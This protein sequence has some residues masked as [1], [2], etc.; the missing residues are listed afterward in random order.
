MRFNRFFY[1]ND[2]PDAAVSAADNPRLTLE[3]DGAN[4][5]IARVAQS[6]PGRFLLSEWGTELEKTAESLC[7]VGV[8]ESERGR[9]R[10]SCPVFLDA[11]Y[12]ALYALSA[13]VAERVAAVLEQ[14][15][16]EMTAIASKIDNGF[17]ASVNLYHL[18]CGGVF[19]GLYFDFLE[20]RRLVTTSKAHPSG[21]DYLVILYEDSARLNAWSRSLLCSYNRFGTEK[22]VFSSFGDSAGERRDFYR[23]AKRLESGR[24]GDSILRALPK[25]RFVEEFIALL[26]GG[27]VD[28]RALAAFEHFGY[29][30]AGRACV[31]VY[32]WR[33]DRAVLQEL[34]HL[35]IGATEDLVCAAMMRVRDAD[36]TANRHGVPAEDSANEIFHLIFG[37]VNEVLTRRGIAAAPKCRVGEG[38]YAKAFEVLETCVPREA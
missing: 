6:P 8:L 9:L 10:L 21:L 32:V 26:D 14:R 35:V 20:Q 15:G 23:T 13:G 25:E 16:E 1:E 30:V 3:N 37:Q 19:D 29:A 27:P 5:V 12:D 22:G 33:R 34:A 17:A 7:R 36:F 18:L 31:P 38:R 28:E 24:L 11:D 2:M 4:E